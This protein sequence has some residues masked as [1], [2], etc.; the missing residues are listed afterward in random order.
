MLTLHISV[1]CWEGKESQAEFIASQVNNSADYLT[2]IYSAKNG[3]TKSGTGDWVHVPDDWFYGKKFKKSLD[4]NKGDIHLQI[5]ADA[6]FENW[7][8]LV[9]RCKKVHSVNKKIGVWAPEVNYTYWKTENVKISNYVDDTLIHVAQTDVI[10]WSFTKDICNKL[11][12]LK[13]EKN[14]YGWGIDWAAIAFALSNDYLVLRDLSLEVSHIKGRGYHTAAA[15][16]QMGLF[17][18]QLTPQ[19]KTIHKLL[20]NFIKNNQKFNIEKYKSRLKKLL[21]S[22]R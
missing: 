6:E 12:G 19:E 10:V 8:Q 13:Y 5:H 2:V 9:N 17:L 22:I 20:I 3:L 21:G 15:V 16:T 11:H 14:N 1:I 18:E 4:L 7:P